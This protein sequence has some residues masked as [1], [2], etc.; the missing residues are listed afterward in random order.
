L[1]LAA[2]KTNTPATES[3]RKDKLSFSSI[4]LHVYYNVVGYISALTGGFGKE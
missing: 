2:K 3:C 4:G 1:T